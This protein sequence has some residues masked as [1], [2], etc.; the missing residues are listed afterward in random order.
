MLIFRG[1]IIIWL[2]SAT[3]YANSSQVVLIDPHQNHAVYI[4]HMIVGSYPLGVLRTKLCNS[5]LIHMPI[6]LFHHIQTTLYGFHQPT[7]TAK[8]HT[9][10]DAVRH[11]IRCNMHTPPRIVLNVV[12]LISIVVHDKI[13]QYKIAVPKYIN[14]SRYTIST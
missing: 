13:I 3:A 14:M 7:Y 12:Q 4:L 8:L 6:S 5:P 9:V 2:A 11:P 1:D 10:F